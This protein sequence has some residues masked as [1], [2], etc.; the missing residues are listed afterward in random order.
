MRQT[1]VPRDT[2]GPSPPEE[3]KDSP[4]GALPSFFPFFREGSPWRRS[5]NKLFPLPPSMTPTSDWICNFSPPPPKRWCARPHGPESHHSLPFFSLRRFLQGV[6]HDA[7]SLHFFV[8]LFSEH[9]LFFFLFSWPKNK[10]KTLFP[11]PC[12][13]FLIPSPSGAG[14]KRC[15]RPPLW[16]ACF[17][18]GGRTFPL[19]RVFS[20]PPPQ[21]FFLWGEHAPGLFLSSF[22]R[23]VF[24]L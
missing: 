9:L 13:F 24:L 16:R 22:G 6:G 11:P 4:D 21:P 7:F 14:K 20:P 2:V 8:S 1:A 10:V 23:P 17:L 5:E 3:N 15:S 18:E 12:C 19:R